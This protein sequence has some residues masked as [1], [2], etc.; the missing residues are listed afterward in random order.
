MAVPQLVFCPSSRDGPATVKW[1]SFQRFLLCTELDSL[2]VFVL[3]ILL[4][5]FPHYFLGLSQS[6]DHCGVG[7]G[8]NMKTKKVETQSQ[9]SDR[10][11]GRIHTVAIT[12]Q[13]AV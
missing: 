6:N 3:V 5:Y 9:G 1:H 8:E 11:G 12:I 13:S 7:L 2:W 10:Y 4:Q